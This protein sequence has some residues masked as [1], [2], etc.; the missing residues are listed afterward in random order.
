MR[1]PFVGFEGPIAS[2]KTTHAKLLADRLQSTLLLEQF[3]GNEFLADFYNQNDRWALPMQ[4]S[5]LALRSAQ[6]QT[7]VA[8][9][10][11]AVV[12]DYSRLKDP[13][14][15]ELLLIDRELRLYQQ[16]SIAFAG[17]LLDHDLIVYLDADNAVLLDRIRRR[18][19]P[20]EAHIDGAYQDRLRGAYEAAF[21]AN[22]H[23]TILRYN[24]SHL[25]LSSA[26]DIDEL[27]EAILASLPWTT[28]ILNNLGEK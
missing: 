14:L 11:S 28:S 16:V 19:R 7:V 23:L 20:Y 12:V 4:L 6:L 8:P 27:H 2:G 13:T 21:A 22:P 18:G 5:F 26:A 9:L 10:Q 15:A 25:D 3:A 1:Y 17:T 24:T